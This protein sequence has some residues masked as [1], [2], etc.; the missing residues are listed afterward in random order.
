MPLLLQQ[1]RRVQQNEMRSALI[2]C[3]IRF[4]KNGRE[5]LFAGWTAAN[6][7]N[8]GNRVKPDSRPD[9]RTHALPNALKLRFLPVCRE[10]ACGDREFRLCAGSA[11]LRGVSCKEVFAL[12]CLFAVGNVQKR[13]RQPAIFRLLGPRRLRK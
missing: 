13:K 2:E 4:P 12:R 10:I 9:K 11:E 6:V 3:L 5:R 1:N 8:A 7:L